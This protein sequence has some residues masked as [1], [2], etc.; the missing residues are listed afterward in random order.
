MID[1][2][3][4][5]ATALGVPQCIAVVD[6]AG[7][8]IAFR[9]MDGAKT[10]SIATATT[11]AVTAARTRN[12]S[13]PLPDHLGLSVALASGGAFTELRGGRPVVIDGECVGAIGVGSGTPEQDESVAD[14]ALRALGTGAGAS[15]PAGGK[16]DG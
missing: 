6:P 13:G 7:D 1:A 11:K 12:N 4:V 10:M 8:L 3:A 14:A 9:R 15:A 5:E 16:E 2:A